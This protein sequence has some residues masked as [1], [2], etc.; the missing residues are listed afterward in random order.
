MA[1]KLCVK[2]TFLTEINSKHRDIVSMYW[3]NCALLCLDLSKG[4]I[5]PI[6]ITIIVMLFGQTLDNNIACD[7]YYIIT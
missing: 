6:K 2:F 3:S 1:V 5:I 4:H 7:L